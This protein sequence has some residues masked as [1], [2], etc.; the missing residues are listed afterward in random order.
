[1]NFS[2]RTISGGVVRVLTK[3][4]TT[5]CFCVPISVMTAM[6]L[7]YFYRGLGV[8]IKCAG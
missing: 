2:F 3:E 5:S 1:M 4:I 7:R 8:K 6:V